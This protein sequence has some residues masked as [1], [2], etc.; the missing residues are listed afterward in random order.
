MIQVV[1]NLHVRYRARITNVHCK[2]LIRA[3]VTR[4]CRCCCLDPWI[5]HHR[6]QLLLRL[7]NLPALTAWLEG[8]CVQQMLWFYLQVFSLGR[9]ML[10][11]RLT[12]VHR[13]TEFHGGA[14]EHRRHYEIRGIS[15]VAL[16]GRWRVI[17]SEEGKSAFDGLLAEAIVERADEDTQRKDTEKGS[18]ECSRLKILVVHFLFF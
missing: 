12:S 10:P 3:V 5:A 2:A 7:L 1:F 14:L 16:G 6:L 9:R 15:D 17:I 4:V 11:H 13:V 18:V 8:R